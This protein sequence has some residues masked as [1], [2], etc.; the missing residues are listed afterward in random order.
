MG[1]GA[2]RSRSILHNAKYPYLCLETVFPALKLT[3][4]FYPHFFLKAANLIKNYW[5]LLSDATHVVLQDHPH[6]LTKYKDK[7]T[8]I[9]ILKLF[10]ELFSKIWKCNLGFSKIP[11]S[12]LFYKLETKF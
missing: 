11:I 2:Q 5:L 4:N 10:S 12:H 1:L 6:H 3:Q 9:S 8:K 7:R